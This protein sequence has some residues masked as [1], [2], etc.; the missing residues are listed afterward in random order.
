MMW[1]NSKVVPLMECVSPG[2][3]SQTP[4]STFSPSEASCAQVLKDGLPE[5]S[6]S[7]AGKAFFG[8]KSGLVSMVTRRDM[9]SFLLVAE[10]SI[11]EADRILS[12]AVAP[13]VLYDALCRRMRLSHGRDMWRDDHLRMRPEW[14]V[15]W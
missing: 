13:D 7:G 8:A 15:L 3:A 14:M 11:D 10:C 2:V 1:Q 6:R 4:V 5:M 9:A 12:G